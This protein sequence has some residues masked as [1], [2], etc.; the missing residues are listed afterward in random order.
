[1]SRM[2]GICAK[3]LKQENS[4]KLERYLAENVWEAPD[5]HRHADAPK[6]DSASTGSA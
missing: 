2:F 5:P 3:V 1:M 6:E 4:V